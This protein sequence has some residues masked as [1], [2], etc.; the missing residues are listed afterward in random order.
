VAAVIVYAGAGAVAQSLES[1]RLTGLL[2][3]MLV[4]LPTVA[5]M[6]VAWWLAS[7]GDPPAARSR[8][9]WAR[10]VRDAGA[11]V[12]PFLQ[13]G[14]VLL[15][16]RALGQGRSTAVRGAVSASVDGIIELTAKLPY[17]LAGLVALLALAPHSRLERPLILA[18]G[19]TAAVVAVLLFARRSWSVVME[20]ATRAISRR[21]PAMLSLD[22]GIIGGEVRDS[23]DR[24]LRERG[25]LWLGFVLHLCC[26]CLGALEIWLAF[27]LLGV[28]LTVLRALA[29]DA[30]VVGLRTFGFMVPAAA[31]VQEA[32]YLVAATVFG[33]SPA[34][35][36]AA[37]LARRARDLALGTATLGVAV[38][39]DPRF[40]V[41]TLAGL[42]GLIGSMRAPAEPAP[43]GPV[44]AVGHEQDTA[45]LAARVGGL[46]VS[47]ADHRGS[48]PS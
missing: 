10:F 17:V 42:L 4:H 22:E 43:S 24:I 1:L 44:P 40:A 34:A 18:F 16:V 36:I 11:E 26:W 8:F 32:S 6:G 47:K 35:A 14:G 33:I 25:R 37:A 48:R 31:G 29:I 7:G 15:G 12:L 3:L 30:A 21:L 2:L 41:L 5:L 13:F 23:F 45:A 28:D 27:R 39:G 46:G 19:V 20:R 9:L 38:V